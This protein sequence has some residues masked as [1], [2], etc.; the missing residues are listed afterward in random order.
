L[1][2]DDFARGCTLVAAVP[3]HPLA[4]LRRGFSPA[5][6]LAKPVARA[7]GLPL[8]RG[9]LRRRLGAVGSIKR[10][11]ARQR[12]RALA[13]AVVARGQLSGE[14]VLLVDDVLTTGA[15]VAACAR[16]LSGI[17]AA[18]VRVAVWARTLPP[19]W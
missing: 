16:A 9:I 19:E 4:V 5:W 1:E 10:L 6:Q 15:T 2:L 14:S 12:E 17:G 18:E 11:G 7:L 3:S 13:D 8:G